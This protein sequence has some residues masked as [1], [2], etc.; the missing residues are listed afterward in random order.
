MLAVLV[1]LQLTHAVA[2]GQAAIDEPS[3]LGPR[4]AWADV[5]AAV[6][7][8]IELRREGKDEEALEVFRDALAHAPTSNRI[9]VQLATALQAL[10][11]WQEAQ[12]YLRQAIQHTEDPY[13]ARHYAELNQALDYV[14]DRL[15][16][17]EIRGTPPGADVFLSGRRIG[18]LPLEPLV[19]PTGSY[20]LEVRLDGY[21]P[22]VRALT[23]SARGFH[24]ERLE[25]LPL[26]VAPSP[27]P[28]PA[29]GRAAAPSHDTR[30]STP[31]NRWIWALAGTGAASG[32]AAIVAV[33]LRER[34]A[35]RWN[36][37]D[38]LAGQRTRGENCASYLDNGRTAGQVAIVSATA[39]GVLLGSAATVAWLRGEN[40]DVAARAPS[41]C[42]AWA[43]GVS[44]AT[45]F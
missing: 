31:S 9:R 18:A 4:P 39:A 30:A 1:A 33:I 27:L 43:G 2:W 38:C 42:F 34:Y 40:D 26:A 21:Y 16:T 19:V 17:I 13:I 15:G 45:S 32:V 5:N 29:P 41:G 10:G 24:R 22:A 11:R 7:R 37:D 36:S 28:A 8:G 3:A 14:S 12:R 35:S 20:V 23:V 44:C 25:L 6:K